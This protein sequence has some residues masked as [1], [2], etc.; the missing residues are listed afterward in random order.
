MHVVKL[1]L[2]QQLTAFLEDL[3]II[4]KMDVRMRMK[5]AM[6]GLNMIGEEEL[7]IVM[8]QQIWILI[9]GRK[10]IHKVLSNFMNF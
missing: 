5:D 4:T 2:L 8:Q 9:R 10:T 1:I 7:M 3:S 6:C